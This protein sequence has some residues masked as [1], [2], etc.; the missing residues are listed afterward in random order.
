MF[1][2]SS[3]YVLPFVA[4][5]NLVS[6]NCVNL[7]HTLWWPIDVLVLFCAFSAHTHKR[8]QQ[9]QNASVDFGRQ[10]SVWMRPNR[11]KHRT[12]IPI[13]S[14]IRSTIP[15]QSSHPIWTS[16][17]FEMCETKIAKSKQSDSTAFKNCGENKKVSASKRC[18]CSVL[19][20]AFMCIGYHRRLFR[21]S[22]SAVIFMPR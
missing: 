20:T 13:V 21:M 18:C 8:W 6:H 11:T 9:I 14:L 4:M 2:F 10:Y 19:R 3:H 15:Q 16:P 1:T 17:L 7:L 5:D 22:R 12:Q